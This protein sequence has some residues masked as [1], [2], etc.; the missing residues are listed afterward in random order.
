MHI[1]HLS[2]SGKYAVAAFLFE[3]RDEDNFQLEGI[4]RAVERARNLTGDLS[5]YYL[6]HFKNDLE[7]FLFLD[8]SIGSTA[9][10]S[11]LPKNEDLEYF[12]R[13]EGS[14]TTPP[15]S[16]GVIWSI[17]KKRIPISHEQV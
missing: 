13:Y 5:F 11:F 4:L 12:Y 10:N 15:C 3:T 6:N 7:L 1:V 9:F 16:E 2:K 17:F 8:Y 14:F